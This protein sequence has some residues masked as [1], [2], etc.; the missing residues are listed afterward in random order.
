MPS[1]F[2]NHH[3]LH[4]IS[5]LIL[6]IS[7]ATAIKP[8]PQKPPP[9]KPKALVLP[10]S[11]DDATLQRIIKLNQ[12]TP[13]TTIPLT[14]DLE[15]HFLWL[16]CDTISKSTTNRRIH[17]NSARC[18][19]AT[20]SNN[21][22][23]KPC[24]NNILSCNITLTNSISHIISKG[25]L[26]ADIVRINSTDG[27]NPIRVVSVPRFSYGCGHTPLLKGLA[28]GVKGIAGFG[29]TKV[30]VPSQFSSFFKFVNK[31]ALCVSSSSFTDGF[32]IFGD[33]PYNLFPGIDASTLLSYTSL[34]QNPISSPKSEY[35]IGVTS[36]K[37]FQNEVKFDKSILSTNKRGIGG[38]KISTTNPYTIL[39]SSIYK[40]VTDAF[41]AQVERPGSF[42]K[43]VNPI[44]PFT[45]C[46]EIGSLPVTRIGVVVPDVNLVMQSEK[47]VWTIS[48]TNSMVAIFS[49]NAY[50]FGFVDGGV[51]AKE[52]IVIGSYQL[53]NNLLQF[54]L[55]NSKLGFSSSLLFSRTRCDN[56]NFTSV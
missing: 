54:D 53:E 45:V 37:I 41:V 25:E 2:H 9:P 29:R 51:N 12:R 24:K 26:N 52:G 35:Y 36:I 49:K 14:L 1:S 20:T 42:A 10:L 11:R 15:G 3:L 33:K 7:T 56:F 34:L 50:C 4:L 21:P 43:R 47:V 32:I 44:K 5:T 19:L 39:H 6:L 38:T 18:A 30:S 40:A 28:N 22:P 23:Y 27:S 13:P 8:P 31:F 17:C 55:V 16:D 48:G 46:Y